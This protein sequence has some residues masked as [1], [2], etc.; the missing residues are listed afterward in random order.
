MN[1]TFGGMGILRF[2]IIRILASF[3]D[4][5][6]SMGKSAKTSYDWSKMS[7]AVKAKEKVSGVKKVAVPAGQIVV[8][9]QTVGKC[10][11]SQIKTDDIKPLFLNAT[12]KV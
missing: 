9:R 4:T 12:G 2:L 10:G 1:V 11:N 6:Q 5:F 8:I 7:A 3:I